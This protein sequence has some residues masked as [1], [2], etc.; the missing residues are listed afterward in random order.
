MNRLFKWYPAWREHLFEEAF[1]FEDDALHRRKHIRSHTELML[2]C[3]LALLER[4]IAMRR[5]ACCG[6]YFIPKTK[7]TTL[8]CDRVIEGNKTCKDLAPALKRRQNKEQDRCWRNMTGCM[9]CI[10]PAW[11]A[12][13]G[14]SIWNALPQKQIYHKKTS[15]FGLPKAQALR[16]KYMAGEILANE[17]L[18][19][20]SKK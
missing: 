18:E 7:K 13:R 20:L 16:K 17:F 3:L 10:M 9:I 2:F 8:Y 12:T 11:N 1:C 15:S 5:C 6:G 14:E 19:Q 4:D